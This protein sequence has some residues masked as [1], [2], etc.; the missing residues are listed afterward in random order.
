MAVARPAGE[1]AEQFVRRTI[2]PGTRR[3]VER[4]VTHRYV[5]PLDRPMRRALAEIG[6]PA[7]GRVHVRTA[8]DVRDRLYGVLRPS[9][10]PSRCVVCLPRHVVVFA[11]NAREAR[12]LTYRARWALSDCDGTV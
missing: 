11:L 3:V 5:Y 2:D 10:S 6:K 8:V 9:P 4:T 12:L 7:H 1:T